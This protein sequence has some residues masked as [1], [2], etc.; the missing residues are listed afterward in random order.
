MRFKSL[1][2]WQIF[3]DRLTRS[4]KCAVTVAG[5]SLPSPGEETVVPFPGR[6]VSWKTFPLSFREF[7]DGKGIENS[8]P[9]S[10]KQQLIIQRAFADC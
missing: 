3:I 5:S 8:G 9:L 7:L 6:G 10:T 1:P 2:Y 4:E